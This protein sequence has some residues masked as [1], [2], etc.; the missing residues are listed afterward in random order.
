MLTYA[1]VCRRPGGG[2][3]VVLPLTRTPY[4]RPPPPPPGHRE[5]GGHAS[6]RD[7]RTGVFWQPR[8]GGGTLRWS[9]GDPASA[10]WSSA[11]W[12]TH[13]SSS[14]T[15]GVGSPEMRRSGSAAARAREHAYFGGG[16]VS[17]EVHA[18]QENQGMLSEEE[19]MQVKK[20]KA[21]LVP[22]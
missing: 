10:N 16:G 11:A 12:T 9:L 19:A 22:Q 5:G 6:S 8:S 4:T 2:A 7:S 21:V 20:K 3:I 18:Y 15:G 1:D 14:R 17:P 13:V